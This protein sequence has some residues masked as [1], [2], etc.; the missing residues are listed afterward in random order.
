M[1]T[2]EEIKDPSMESNINAS[3]YERPQVQVDHIPVGEGIPI[4]IEKVANPTVGIGGA[5]G[6]WGVNV[7]NEGLQEMLKRELG[8]TLENG[9]IFN[10]AELG[11]LYRQ[12]TPTM[13]TEENV[14]LEVEVGKRFLTEAAAACGWKPEEVEAVLVG[15]SGPV[16]DDYVV[17]IC[18]AAGIPESALKVSIH[19]ACDGSV[20]G[21]NLAL[22]PFLP[23]HKRIGRNLANELIGKKVLLGGIE[24]LTRFLKTARDKN[25]VQLFGNG[26][27]IIGLIPGKS[28]KFL[29]GKSHEVYDEDGLLAFH[30]YYPHS[31]LKVEGQSMIEV[32]KPKENFIRIAGL[33]HEPPEG[34]SVEMAGM[35]GMVKLFV[36]SGVQVV[37][38]VYQAYQQKMTE[39]GMPGK[40]IAVAIVHHANLKI[41]QLKEKTLLR[42]GIQLSMPWL[43]NEFGNVSAA[44]NMIAFLRKLQSLHPGDNVLFDGF[45]AGTYYDVLAVELGG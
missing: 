41:N 21:L 34:Y 13:S 33:M 39:M 26:A 15:S 32:S 45:G 4:G 28:M 22:N 38:D 6:T 44:S 1:S 18:Q 19:K 14:A 31:K 40:E 24:G 37:E 29:V 12:Y 11:F 42:E 17:R 8:K 30:M 43:L 23:E 27:G 3:F 7:P 35:I 9:E 5:Y 16:I 20:A 36:R 25:A 10:L 2:P